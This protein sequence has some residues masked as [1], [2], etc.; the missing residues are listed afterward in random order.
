MVCIVIFYFFLLGTLA[1]RFFLPSLMSV[2]DYLRMPPTV[3]GVVLL[4][5]GN[6]APEIFT[7]FAQVKTGAYAQ[8]IGQL[9]GGAMFVGQCLVGIVTMMKLTQVKRRPFLRDTGF[10]IFTVCSMFIVFYDHDIEM[11]EA[12][13]WLCLYFTYVL[14][15]IIGRIIYVK[16][17]E[18][19][20][21]TL[22]LK[23]RE[24]FVT[25]AQYLPDTLAVFHFDVVDLQDL[26]QEEKMQLLLVVVDEIA[27]QE[28]DLEKKVKEEA[29][30]PLSLQTQHHRGVLLQLLSGL[31]PERLTQMEFYDPETGKYRRLQTTQHHDSSSSSASS[32][33]SSD[34]SVSSSSSSSSSS[35][36][37]QED[38]VDR[39]LLDNTS[40]SVNPTL[41]SNL[42]SIQVSDVTRSPGSRKLSIAP[43]YVMTP[44]NMESAFYGNAINTPMDND[45]E[46]LDLDAK[47]PEN[48]TEWERFLEYWEWN[49]SGKIGKAFAIFLFPLLF[50]MHCM[51]HW[52]E[53][54]KYFRP[55]YV[56]Q[57]VGFLILIYFN[58]EYWSTSVDIQGT[59]VL[60]IYF[61][62]PCAVL[63][64]V[65][66]FFTTKNQGPPIYNVLLVLEGLMGSLLCI[67][68]VAEEL[69]Y[70]LIVLGKLWNINGTIMGFTVL[71][72]GNSIGDFVSNT[73]IAW[74]GFPEM[75]I[76]ACY[77]S[78]ISN[79]L[80]GLGVSFL[81]Q[82]IVKDGAIELA[83][84]G[85][86]P[87]LSN[88][89]YIGFFFL[90][91]GLMF[92]LIVVPLHNFTYPRWASIA[93]IVN[94][95][96]F[97]IMSGLLLMGI[98]A[99]NIRFWDL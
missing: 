13:M 31:D 12:I 56:I 25:L 79:L 80:M 2:A 61:L 32:S 88:M 82:C 7:V 37:D 18:E 33:S 53:E 70:V 39:R 1:D 66:I 86:E 10:F 99:N 17:K 24:K 42:D 38:Y 52:A 85:A 62:L 65:I 57:P 9:L 11:W 67:N 40:P 14:A 19:L 87:D 46:V 50:T 78:P 4:G 20:Q 45:V 94:Y 15:V 59:P 74:K 8:S 54:D 95:V 6:G 96:C 93:L 97:L 49:E 71:A 27:S 30:K 51:M 44:T 28:K 81:A 43:K 89:H 29:D 60:L 98:V 55:F 3:S 69:V 36:E 34:T 22:L 84:E 23:E 77:S 47:D 76:G 41:R 83:V 68:L 16:R 90:L 73:L 5:I 91:L 21:N 72:W 92:C 58:G 75:A 48:I 64:S 63:L 26:T 35:S